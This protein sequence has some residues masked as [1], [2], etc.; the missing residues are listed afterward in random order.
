MKTSSGNNGTFRRPT[1][2][3]VAAR[4]G[5]S[6]KS[7]ANVFNNYPHV[8]GELRDRVETAARE[9]NYVQNA[10]AKGLRGQ[11][12]R[13]IGLVVPDIQHP[14]FAQLAGRLEDLA[15]MEGYGLLIC[16]SHDDAVRQ[17][18]ALSLMH[19]RRVDGV[20]LCAA[21][22]SRSESV[23]R[24]L[25][26]TPFVLLHRNLRG[27]HAPQ[28]Q[29]DNMQMGRIAVECL[30]RL[31]HR[32]IAHLSGPLTLAHARA[33]LAGVR[34]G[35]TEAGI[36]L[37]PEFV[38]EGN[39]SFESGEE[40]ARVLL[41]RKYSPTAFI[42]ESD[43]IAIGVLR[44]CDNLKLNVP[45]DVS[46]IGLDDFPFAQYV[47]PPLTNVAQPAESFAQEGLHILRSLIEGTNDANVTKLLQPYLVERAS[48]AA[49]PKAKRMARSVA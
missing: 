16:N 47:T 46:V 14:F 8:S 15:H 18:S 11:S 3:D 39:Y 36:R 20:L 37:R 5:V 41:N 38:L 10:L 12:T 45:G 4:A 32:Q 24:A 33:R 35:L 19:E 21:N 7:V 13:T 44:A 30:I 6:F 9:L 2:R 1:I 48:T 34:A 25:G 17:E 26:N 27:A 42:A 22:G 40:R 31:G 29:M 23:R 43:T 28:I 49:P